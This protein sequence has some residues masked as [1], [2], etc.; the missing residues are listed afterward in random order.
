MTLQSAGMTDLNE[1]PDGPKRPPAALYRGTVVHKRLRP[2]EHRLSYNVFTIVADVDRMDELNRLKFFSID[3]FNLYGFRPRDHGNRDGNSVAQFAWGEVKK[4]GLIE[5]VQRIEMVF[6]PR[7][8]GYAF[9]PLTVYYCLRASGEP[10]MMIYEVRNTFGEDLTYI[11]QAGDPHGTVFTHSIGKQFYVSPF[12]DVEGSYDF[13]VTAPA[14]EMTFGVALRTSEGAMLRTH[15]KATR[16]PLSDWALVKVF[17]AY[18]LMT[19]KVMMGI[20]WEAL[21]LWRKGL[22]LKTRPAAPKP[23]IVYG[24]EFSST[25]Q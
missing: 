9:N 7:I 15:F 18:P 2:V 12:N 20:H 6:Y 16:Q 25:G 8:L 19:V 3:R 10:A 24:Q 4:C 21:K 13:H 22:T 17:F 23:R 14:E 11:L 1:M 5:D